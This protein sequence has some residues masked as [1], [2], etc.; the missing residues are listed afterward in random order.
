MQV[1]EIESEGLRRAYKVVVPA[2]DVAHRLATRLAEIGRSV[3]LP[4]FR[5]GKV[6]M[7][8]IKQRYTD[9]VMGEILERTVSESSEKAISERELRPAARPKIEVTSFAEGQDLEFTMAIEVLPEIKPMDFSELRLE[10]LKARVSDDEIDKTLARIAERHPRSAPIAEDRP[11]KAG[12]LVVIDFVGRIGETEFEG[13][14]ARGFELELGSNRFVPGFEDQL[15]GRKAG[16]HVTVNVVFPEEYGARELAGK[17]A[18]FEVDV[19]EI[20]D[21]VAVPVDDAL[22]RELGLESLAALRKSL[23]ERLERE[24][25]AISRSRLKRALLDELAEAHDFMLPEGVVEAELDSIW[26][27]VKG[28]GHETAGEA[29][30]GEQPDPGEKDEDELRAEC[31]AIAERRVRLGLLLGEVGR[32]NNIS[33]TPEEVNKALYAEAARHPGR[34]KEVLGFYR[35][36]P[37]ALANLRAPI[38]EDKVVDFILEMAQLSERE[39]DAEE[40]YMTPDERREAEAQEGATRE[41]AADTGEKAAKKKKKT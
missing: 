32:V 24:H 16:E 38:Y 3:S 15:E 41:T 5:P 29:D 17:A 1:T 40:L 12:D 31:R 4:G 11:S 27:Q 25:A 23:R 36:V 34:E 39:V 10:R 37:Q 33:V 7:S 22:A 26:K 35:K 6:P 14:S 8:L 9:S 28:E 13:G 30:P 20:R 19:K 21:K 2:G 18:T